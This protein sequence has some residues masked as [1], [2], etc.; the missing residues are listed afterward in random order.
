LLKSHEQTQ[1]FSLPLK[2]RLMEDAKQTI[3]WLQGV[4]RLIK[5]TRRELK[6]WPRESIILEWFLKV[7]NNTQEQGNHE[8]EDPRAYAQELNPDWHYENCPQQSAVSGSTTLIE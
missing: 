5:I 8:A 3:N 2:D 7:K 1:W 4:K 6:K